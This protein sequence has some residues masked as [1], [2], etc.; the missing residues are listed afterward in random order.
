MNLLALW[1]VA[2]ISMDG[3]LDGMNNMTHQVLDVKHCSQGLLMLH[4][5]QASQKIHLQSVP[6]S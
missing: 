4:H 6:E 1:F 5:Q 2:L 3:S